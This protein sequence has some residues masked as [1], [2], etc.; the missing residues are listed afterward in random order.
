MFIDISFEYDCAYEEFIYRNIE[1]FLKSDIW[2][3]F[4]TNDGKQYL[5]NVLN[6]SLDDYELHE[7]FLVDNSLAHN[8]RHDIGKIA[9]LE[10]IITYSWGGFYW[11]D[12]EHTKHL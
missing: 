2:V 3:S 11:K 12:K 7:R 8:I 9:A 1:K 5:E 10:N 6:K 4:H